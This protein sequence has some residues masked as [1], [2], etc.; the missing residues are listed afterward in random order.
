MLTVT[1]KNGCSFSVAYTVNVKTPNTRSK[2]FVTH[3]NLFATL[4][5]NPNE[6]NFKVKLTGKPTRKIELYIIDSAGKILQKQIIR[7]FQ[8]ECIETFRIY[9]ISGIYTMLIHSD[10]EKL[11]RQF[12]IN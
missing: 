7:N 4:F 1:D 6:G 12:I 10:N 9:L 11:S 8:G 2:I 5:P 3:N